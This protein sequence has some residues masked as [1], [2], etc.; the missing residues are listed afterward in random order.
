M[1]LW[2]FLQTIY[3]D[4]QVVQYSVV[5]LVNQSM[6][7]ELSSLFPSF[8][9][10]WNSGNVLNIMLNIQFDQKIFV[11]FLI[12]FAKFFSVSGS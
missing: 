4:L 1:I 7:S 5:Q 9:D 2:N 12:M 6:N 11:F 3:S 8:L 10:N